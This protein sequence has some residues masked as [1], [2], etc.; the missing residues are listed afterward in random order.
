MAATEFRTGVIDAVQ[1]YKE[2]WEMIKPQ[3][4]LIFAI[5]L[6]GMLVG[7]IV[8]LI[9][10]GPMMVGIYFCL[11]DLYDRK[12]VDFGRLFKGFDMFLPSFLLSLVIM[13]PVLLMVV[14]IY[15][16]MIGFAVAGQ[17]MDE[18]ELIAFLAVTVGIEL[19]FAVIMVCIHTLVIFSFPLIADRRLGAWQAVV[20]SA[21]AVKANMKGVIGLFLVGFVVVL[22]GY[23]MLCVGLYLVLPLILAANAVAYRKVF[24]AMN[25]GYSAPPPPNV[26]QGI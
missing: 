18:S 15:V 6:V 7:G 13:L 2:A 5:V 26:Y 25:P 20:T 8:P 24:P 1:C 22:V 14:M 4:W 16:P 23:M 9:L 17:R 21:R 10:I 11:F 12:P 3:Y 19:V